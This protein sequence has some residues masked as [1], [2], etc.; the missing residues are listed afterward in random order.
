[1]KVLLLGSGGREHALAWKIAQSPVLSKLFIAPGNAG[2]GI[3]GTNVAIDPLKFNEVRDFILQEEIDML[4]IGPEEPLVKGL[5]DFL[6]SNNRLKRLNI[7]GPGKAGAQLE[8]SKDFAKQFMMKY[9]IPTASYLT[10]TKENISEGFKFLEKMEAPYV[11]KAD[12]LAAGKGVLITHS[13]EE[14][15]QIVVEMLEGKFKEAG[16]KVIIEQFLNGIELSVFILTDGKNWVLLPEAKDYK[17]IGEGDTGLNTGGM[18]AISPVPFADALFLDKVRKR[19]I[20]PTIRGLIQE[21]IDYR[22][23]I[24]FG[25]MNVSGNPY[26][27]EYNARMGDPEAEAI[28]PRIKSDIIDLFTGVGERNLNKVH[29]EFDDS[30]SASVMLAS[31]GYPGNFEKGKEISGINKVTESLVFHA[32]TKMDGNR[33][34]TAGGRVMAITSLAKTMKDALSMSYRCAGLVDFENKYFRK[35]I[36]FDLC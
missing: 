10:V 24:F 7:I 14:A 1:M 8:G 5:R 36:G 33:L 34:V 26:V 19:I 4:V 2:T 9:S 22:G 21:N 18:G 11:L 17:R 20:T 12:G 27:I 30:Y 23:F 32:G 16:K 35:D 3:T 15:K 29:A 13:L 31:G 6:E 25:L 28:V